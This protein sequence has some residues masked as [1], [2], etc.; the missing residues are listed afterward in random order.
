MERE[1]EA[2]GGRFFKSDRKVEFGKGS[3]AS[4]ID[5]GHMADMEAVSRYFSTEYHAIVPD[6]ASLYPVDSGRDDAAGG[7]EHACAQDGGGPGDGGEVPPRFLPVTNPGGPS[8]AWLREMFID[9]TPDF[10]KYPALKTK[11]DPKDWLYLPAALD[12]N[13]YLDPEYETSLAVLNR[14]RYEQLRHGDW[15]VF[16]GQFFSEWTSADACAEVEIPQ[17]TDVF[18]SMDWGYNAPGVIL[19]WACLPDGHYHLF[20]ELKFQQ[21][22]AETVGRTWHGV[23]REFGVSRGMSWRIRRCGRRPGRGAGSRLPRRC[24]GCGCRCG[25]GITTGRTAGSG[26]TSCC[27]WMARGGRG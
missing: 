2:L 19:W 18:C 10:D 22:T 11:Y 26:A 24:S 25:A 15:T 12:D 23:N 5:C 27:G 8:A 6:E 16:S 14:V 20:K 1:V 17:G 9:H 3:A 21:D 7:V 4:I 13:P